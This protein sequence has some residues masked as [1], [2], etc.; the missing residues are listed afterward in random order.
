ME[1]LVGV[2]GFGGKGES[3]FE[4]LELKQIGADL[5]PLIGQHWKKET[6]NEFSFEDLHLFGQTKRRG[7]GFAGEGMRLQLILF[8]R[9]SQG[10]LTNSSFTILLRMDKK[11][12]SLAT[13]SRVLARTTFPV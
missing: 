5:V 13:F 11:G 9:K 6:I 2:K 10:H 7:V 3:M 4:K 8:T 12:F 1:F